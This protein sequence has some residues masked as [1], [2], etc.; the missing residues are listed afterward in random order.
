MRTKKRTRAYR[1]SGGTPT[2]PARWFYGLYRAL[3]GDRAFLSP[4]SAE[5]RLRELDASVGASGPHDFTVRL[6]PFVIGASA[7]IASRPAAVTIMRRLSRDGTVDGLTV[8]WVSGTE[9]FCE[10]GWTGEATETD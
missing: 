4:S 1:S 8:I 3:L 6:A 7:S 2:F 10:W 9:I 5:A